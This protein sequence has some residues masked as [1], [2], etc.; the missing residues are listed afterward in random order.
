MLSQSVALLLVSIAGGV[1]IGTIAGLLP[2][3]HVNNTSAL[4]LG[5]S[6]A[7]VAAGVPP[8]YI[9]VAIVASTVA[10]SFLDI[11]PSVFLGA[12]D[13]ATVLAVMPGHR[14]LL[15]GRGIEA[16]RLSAAGSGLAI[17]VSMLLILPLSFIFGT[18]YPLMWDNM[19]LILIAISMFIILSNDRDFPFAGAEEG[20]GM[21]LKGAI[22]FFAAGLLGVLSFAIEPGLVP[23]ISIAAPTALLPLLSGLFGAPMLLL[24]TFSGPAIPRQGHHDFSMPGREIG[25]AALLG[26][27]AG[28]MVSWFPAV[29]AGVATSITSLFSRNDKDSDRRYLISVS[30]VNT[31][32]AVFSLV[33]LYVIGKPRSGAVAAAEEL[34]EGFFDYGTFV[35]FLVVICVA[36]ALSYLLVLWIGGHAAEAFRKVNYRLMNRIVLLFLGALCML[37]TGPGGLAIFLISASVGMAA[38]LL[39]VRKTCLMGVLLLPCILYFL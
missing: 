2:G 29:S 6:P 19:A 24:S 9:A 18:I 17:V 20:A 13:D 34:L 36:G 12:P 3:V 28:A 39:D 38:H 10:Q 5:I 31:A 27:A 15:D 4:L 16:V 30:G 22:I 37:M 26:T 33:A 11:V 7:L 1:A 14:M 8:L 32:N 23:I 35:L 25:Q 21:I